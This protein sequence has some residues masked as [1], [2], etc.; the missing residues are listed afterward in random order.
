MFDFLKNK[1]KIVVFDIG[2]QK[3][4]A[5]SFRIL[6]NKPVIAEMEYQ[7]N[8]ISDQ[9]EFL[10]SE[11]NKISIPPSKQWIHILP[12]TGDISWFTD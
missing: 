9:F 12:L 1:K 7:R 6:D 10:D 8:D 11:Q 4:G 2:A 5:I 3:I